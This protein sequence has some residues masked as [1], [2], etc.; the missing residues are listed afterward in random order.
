MD[1]DYDDTP[2]QGK[3][4]P[5]DSKKVS[6][7]QLQAKNVLTSRDTKIVIKNAV[8]TFTVA[9]NSNKTNLL[10]DTKGKTVFMKLTV[11]FAKPPKGTYE[12]YLNLP[13]NA[14]ANPESDYFSGF[15]TFFGAG[16]HAGMQGMNM[17]NTIMKKTFTYEIT[18]EF[19]TSKALT[20]PTFN[21]SILKSGAVP[22]EEIKVENVS[23]LIQ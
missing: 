16:H 18:K 8:T 2:V 15:M 20:K 17:P 9:N 5:E 19:N 7:L 12:I 10:R 23:I 22:Q 6:P 3:I 13:T 21:I 1:Y 14:N 11:S 4:E